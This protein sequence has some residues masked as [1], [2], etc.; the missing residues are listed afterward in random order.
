MFE[1]RLKLHGL[2]F[3]DKQD[4]N[5]TPPR[6]VL[7]GVYRL[8][9]IV[10]GKSSINRLRRDTDVTTSRIGGTF[11]EVHAVHPALLR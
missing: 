7:V 1:V 11:K 6:F 3:I 10:F 5:N 4:L 8:A 2:G 9:R